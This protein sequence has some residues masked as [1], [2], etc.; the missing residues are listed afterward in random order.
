MVEKILIDFSGTFEDR[1]EAARALDD[2][3][4]KVRRGDWQASQNRCANPK[5]FITED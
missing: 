3:A 2:A 1:K 5:L 4:E